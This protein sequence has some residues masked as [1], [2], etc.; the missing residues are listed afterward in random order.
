M[1]RCIFTGPPTSP[2]ASDHSSLF[3]Y[4]TSPHTPGLAPIERAHQ[5]I[6]EYRAFL[7]VG[8]CDLEFRWRFCE[9]KIGIFLTAREVV[10]RSE[11]RRKKVR[12]GR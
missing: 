11:V 7:A 2:L 10:P 1:S 9:P 3:E 8:F 6:G 12:F 4:L 5:A